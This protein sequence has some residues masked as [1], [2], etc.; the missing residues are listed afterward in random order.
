MG[1]R[2]GTGDESRD[3]RMCRRRL[4]DVHGMRDDYLA[5]HPPRKLS[6][7][8]DTVRT[9]VIY[10]SRVSSSG[11]RS[12]KDVE[13]ALRAARRPGA[14]SVR[15]PRCVLPPLLAGRLAPLQNI[16]T[17]EHAIVSLLARWVLNTAPPP[18][19][20]ERAAKKLGAENVDS[21]VAFARGYAASRAST[22]SAPP[23]GYRRSSGS[24]RGAGARR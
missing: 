11:I 14:D 22:G 4:L 8:P 10:D 13:R 19:E 9:F 21:I 7:C 6:A 16:P 18:A 5:R 20:V 12:A 1:R 15:T 17:R 2:G 3:V 24:R 23:E